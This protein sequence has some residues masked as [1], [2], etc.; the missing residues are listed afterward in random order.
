LDFAVMVIGP[1]A[2]R[3]ASQT[4]RMEPCFRVEASSLAG[5]VAKSTRAFIRGLDRKAR[6]DANKSG[7]TIFANRVVEVVEDGGKL[8]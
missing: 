8:R 5:A 2:V 3:S 4:V 6:L 1:L 7:L